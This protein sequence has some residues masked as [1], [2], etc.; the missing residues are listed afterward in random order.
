M[1]CAEICDGIVDKTLVAGDLSGYAS[2]FK[3]VSETG[4]GSFLGILTMAA[5]D[6]FWFGEEF[7]NVKFLYGSYG[8]QAVLLHS[9]FKAPLAQPWNAFYGQTISA[10]V[11]VTVYNFF[12]EIIV[13][14][15]YI[16]MAIAVS[17]AIMVM[18]FF[19][20]VHPPGT[21]L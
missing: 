13:L 16:Q 4:I 21:V 9:A 20:C 7:N 5:M 15:D 17:F 2:K 10:F 12:T 6:K 14:D 3:G 8:A 19:E 18:E 1:N 11:G